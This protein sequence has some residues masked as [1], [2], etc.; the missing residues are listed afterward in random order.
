MSLV[1]EPSGARE[2]AADNAFDGEG[3]GGAASSE[4]AGIFVWLGNGG[5]DIES[6]DVVRLGGGQ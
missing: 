5:R 3:S 4:A 6:E 1:F 2:I